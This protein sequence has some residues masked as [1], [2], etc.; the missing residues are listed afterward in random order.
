MHYISLTSPCPCL[1]GLFILL[2][3]TLGAGTRKRIKTNGIFQ[4]VKLPLLQSAS[5]MLKADFWS[6]QCKPMAK[7]A[8]TKSPAH[9]ILGVRDRHRAWRSTEKHT[10]KHEDTIHVR[11]VFEIFCLTQR[12]GSWAGLHVKRCLTTSLGDE[13]QQPCENAEGKS[14]RHHSWSNRLYLLSDQTESIGL[15]LEH[16]YW[17]DS[18]LLFLSVF[19]CSFEGFTNLV[20]NVSGLLNHCSHPLRYHGYRTEWE[21]LA[22][23]SLLTQETFKHHLLT[24]ASQCLARTRSRKK[25]THTHTTIHNG[26]ALP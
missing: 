15:H 26:H 16:G 11:S 25:H 24:W 20:Q 3:L 4:T 14:W 17:F 12:K 10:H 19:Q 6:Q 2:W 9:D 13:I 22:S 1:L 23:L 7:Q 18:F 21:E 5:A 8:E